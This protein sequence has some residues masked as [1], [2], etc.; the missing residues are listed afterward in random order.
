MDSSMEKNRLSECLS[1]YLQQHANNPVHWYPW[2]PEALE[3]ARVENKPIL[4]SI[5]YS[6][7]HWCHVMA[8]E[9]FEDEQTAKLMNKLFVN[10]KV[11]KEERPDLDKIYQTTHQ[12]LNERG[13]GWPL[14]VFLT[15]KEHL[16]FF[17]GTYFPKDAKYGL[18]AFHT[19]L[20]TIAEL[21]RTKYSDIENQ[22][23]EVSAALASMSKHTLAPN[24]KLS[25][26]PIEFALDQL[27]EEFDEVSGGFGQA[28][29]FPMA[30][31]LQQLLR[32]YHGE[33]RDKKSIQML[34]KTLDNMAMGGIYDQVGGGFFRY[35]VDHH[36]EIPHFEKMLYDNA[37]LLAI[38]AQAS[39]F[40]K[41]DYYK[42][43]AYETANWALKKMHDPGGGFYS[44]I[45]ADSLGIEGKFYLWNKDEIQINLLAEEYQLFATVFN[46]RQTSNFNHEWH[47]H[48][49]VPIASLNAHDL[50]LLNSSKAKLFQLRKQRIA[51]HKDQKI[52]TSWN[53]LMIR[54]LSLAGFIFQEP[55]FMEA[56]KN[57]LYFIKTH[58]HQS[59]K[60][61]ACYK[62]NIAYNLAYLDDYAFLLDSI[63]YYLQ[64][65]FDPELL[66]FAKTLADEAIAN[67]F[68]TKEGGFYFTAHEHEKLIQR[69]KLLTDDV[70]PSGNGVMIF[71]LNR[72]G[73]L[74][75][76]SHYLDIA[77]KSLLYSWSALEAHP[78]LNQSILHA[79]EEM[80]QPPSLLV[81]LYKESTDIQTWKEAVIK[82]YSPHQLC[83]F[84]P[85][86]HKNHLPVTANFNL[87]EHHVAAILCKGNQCQAPVYDLD[88]F[89]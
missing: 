81:I 69:P 4:L 18:P 31:R 6:A 16:P 66:A 39:L 57:A 78:A 26:E 73:H 63:L 76:N 80:V 52:L 84:I 65:E 24:V 54:G 60:L 23:K 1:P 38:Y 44:T 29:K 56:A 51:P 8:H 9:S 77:H 36:W 5:G 45:D 75:G 88:H 87:G 20:N 2:G 30:S 89:R 50:E 67:Y 25:N 58:L 62:N 53:G 83:L 27:E 21:Y 72:L 13:G 12:L 85:E 61:Y 7:C 68:D 37:L 11:D 48:Q 34:K 79:L 15:P 43:I 40:L 33:P 19:V 32:R 70:L 17:S 22:G 41:N 86:S 46:L 42:T 74:L 64:M 71:A 35:S 82:Q 59:T 55:R 28:P 3:K 47:L 10:I 14:T 49:V